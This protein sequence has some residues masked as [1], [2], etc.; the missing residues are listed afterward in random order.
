M[1]LYCILW[2]HFPPCIISLFLELT[3]V[4][5]F[6]LLCFLGPCGWVFP[7]ILV[8]SQYSFLHKHQVTSCPVPYSCPLPLG[9][10][11]GD[12]SS[13]LTCMKFLLSGLSGVPFANLPTGSGLLFPGSL[14]LVFPVF[15]FHFVGVQHSVLPL[16]KGAREVNFWDIVWKYLLSAYPGD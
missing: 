7:Y 9:I 10:F 12:P 8:A 13:S 4:W 1:E 16:K 6:R 2:L 14:T 5:Y 3:I 15:I 11:L